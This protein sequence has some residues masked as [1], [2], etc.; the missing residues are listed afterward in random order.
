[1]AFI[2]YHNIIGAT[3]RDNVLVAVDDLPRLPIKSIHITNVK[4]D[5]VATVSVYLYKDSVDSLADDETYF[6]I[7]EVV[8]PVSVSLTLDNSDLLKFDN[9]TTGYSLNMSV[10]SSDTVDVVIKI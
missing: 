4:S 8:I 6:I 2:P 9:S 1:M 5:G 7:S 10:G 3:L